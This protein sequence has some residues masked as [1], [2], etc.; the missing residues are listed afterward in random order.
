MRTYMP[1][2][3]FQVHLYAV[4]RRKQQLGSLKALSTYSKSLRCPSQFIC[5]HEETEKQSQSISSFNIAFLK[6][7]KKGE[8]I[9]KKLSEYIHTKNTSVKIWKHSNLK[10]LIFKKGLHQ[11]EYR[12]FPQTKLLSF[13][14]VFVHS[15]ES[16]M[17]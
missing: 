4:D 5:S 6:R 14:C 17:M 8:I 3:S 13:A 1:L 7:K 10:L 9:G 15:Q 2:F 11:Q 16:Q 12:A